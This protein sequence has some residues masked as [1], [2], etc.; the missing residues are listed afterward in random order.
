MSTSET[1]VSAI[2][3]VGVLGAAG[4]TH[5]LNVPGRHPDRRLRKELRAREER[6]QQREE[7]R[8]DGNN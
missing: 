1:S 5:G 8:T 4:R 6:D 2:R 7:P 3:R